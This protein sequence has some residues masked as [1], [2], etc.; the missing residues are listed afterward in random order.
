MKRKREGRYGVDRGEPPQYFPKSPPMILGQMHW[1]HV[2]WTDRSPSAEVVKAL[3]S[4][5]TSVLF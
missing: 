4:L 2:R 5:V 3:W 1:Y